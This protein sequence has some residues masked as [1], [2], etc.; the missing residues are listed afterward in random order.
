MNASRSHTLFHRSPISKPQPIQSENTA[1]TSQ[2]VFI[3][4][5]CLSFFPLMYLLG[6]FV[7]SLF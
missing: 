7:T 5:A 2:Q 4:I 1:I 3:T 6:S